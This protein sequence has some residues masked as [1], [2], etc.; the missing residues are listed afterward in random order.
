[1]HTIIAVRETEV[2]VASAEL[3]FFCLIDIQSFGTLIDIENRGIID[4]FTIGSLQNTTLKPHLIG[5]GKHGHIIQYHGVWTCV[6]EKQHTSLRI[7]QG[8]QL[9]FGVFE[10][11]DHHVLVLA[12]VDEINKD[13]ELCI[14]DLQGLGH[15]GEHVVSMTFLVVAEFHQTQEQQR[16]FLMRNLGFQFLADRV[17][18]RLRIRSHIAGHLI[19]VP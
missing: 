6:G 19:D 16:G 17:N 7:Q 12:V 1:M 15:G 4:G 10:L 3:H 9:T 5:T 11:M 13:L 2:N 18:G 8:L 14:G